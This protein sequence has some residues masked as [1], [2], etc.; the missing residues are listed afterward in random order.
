MLCLSHVSQCSLGPSPCRGP[1][2]RLLHPGGSLF[3]SGGL[4][5]LLCLSRVSQ[6]SL[7][8]S[9]CRGLQFR[10]LHCGGLLLRLLQPG[11]LLSCPGGLLLRLLHRFRPGSLLCWFHPGS[12][13][14]PGFLLCKQRHNYLC[15]LITIVL[16]SPN[17]LTLALLFLN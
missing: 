15:Y 12:L 11:R 17:P 5:L 10:L 13:L 4:L 9:P 1:L 14:R 8:P 16:V 7:G 2:L 3:R 6:C